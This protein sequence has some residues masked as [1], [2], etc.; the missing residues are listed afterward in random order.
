MNN[1]SLDELIKT[2]EEHAI[3]ADE[4]REQAKVNFPHA[5]WVHNDFNI[6]R[7]LHHICKEI[8]E[9]TLEQ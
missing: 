3:S 6:A 5:E 4:Q 2:F 1:Y 9:L 8:Q 7:A